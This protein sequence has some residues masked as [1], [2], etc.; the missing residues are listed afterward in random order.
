MNRKR[1]L[2]LTQEML[3]YLQ[4][5]SIAKTVRYL[6]PFLQQKKLEIRLLM[7]RFGN[8]NEKRHRLHEVVRLS[9]LNI[10]INEDDYPLIIKV[11][12]L[13]DARMQVYFLDNEELFSRKFDLRDGSNQFFED[14]D[15][16]M[17]F[18]CKGALETVKKLGW[19]PD[20]VH[21]HG[22]MTSFVPLY[23]K[24]V[25]HD[26]PMYKDAKVFYTVY[27]NGF[28]E[29]L[30]PDLLAKANVDG[31]ISEADFV[32]YAPGTFIALNNGAI[33]YSDGIAIGN[34]NLDPVLKDKIA[35]LQDK[36]VLNYMPEN[37]YLDAH[38]EFYK[39]QLTA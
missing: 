29:T 25:Y 18:F 36:P 30:G 17:S 28:P 38:I 19:K 34:E 20:I 21:C 10:V 22:W 27:E 8:I 33:N 7:P 16:R 13:S 2:I 12:S 5:S 15:I 37:E 3:P 23:M 31:K 24:K 26:D 9:G 6:A 35:N 14:N 32:E 1:I 4:L 39:N 11:A